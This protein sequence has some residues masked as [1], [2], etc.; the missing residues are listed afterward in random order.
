MCLARER[1]VGEEFERHDPLGSQFEFKTRPTNDLFHATPSYC[2]EL[3][4]ELIASRISFAMTLK[5][6]QPLRGFVQSV[7]SL[8]QT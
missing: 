3:V 4:G 6:S 7:P 2:A 5:R 1:K 8:L